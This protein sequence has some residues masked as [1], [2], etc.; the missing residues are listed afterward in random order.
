M[1]YLPN[2][3]V[4]ARVS[5]TA[6]Q[7]ETADIAPADAWWLAVEFAAAALEGPG[8]DEALTVVFDRVP[9]ESLES[10]LAVVA[11]TVHPDAGRVAAAVR[12]F[13]AS[14][15]TPSID[16]VYQL[17]VV[18][19]HW[20]P[21]IWRRVLVPATITLGDLHAVIQILFGWD[22][23]H[24]HL[25]EVGARRYSDPFFDLSNLEMDDE[26]V[27]RLREVFTG[28]TKKIRYEYDF[29]ASWWHEIALEKI[30]GR[31][32][33]TVYPRCTRFASDSPV[34]YWSEDDPQEAEPFD[35]AETN[36]RLA[37]LGGLGEEHR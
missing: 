30:L 26:S 23:D 7:D 14:G 28:A 33:G 24:L 4:H 32:P 12:A 8:P 34:E 5:L 22:G 27:V 37:R 16:Q 21:P 17:K 20:R 1:A 35:L 3:G 2:L 6:A 10:R 13:V 11:D 9:G 18:L 19:V 31:E 29:G 25:F 36:R 15:A